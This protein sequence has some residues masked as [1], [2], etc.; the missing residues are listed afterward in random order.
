[1][2]SLGDYLIRIPTMIPCLLA[3]CLTVL[4]LQKFFEF[5]H[6]CL[7]FSYHHLC[8]SEFILVS[9]YKWK[10]N[11]IKIQVQKAYIPCIWWIYFLCTET[12]HDA[13]RNMKGPWKL[14]VSQ[15][16]C[17]KSSFR[18]GKPCYITHGTAPLD[19]MVAF[20]NGPDAFGRVVEPWHDNLFE[21][22]CDYGVKNN[23]CI[24]HKACFQE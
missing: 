2:L 9:P 10:K 16:P 4:A 15:C 18:A 19:P 13:W 11:R 23:R 8:G 12:K 6:Y 3:Y 20:V 5:S 17:W 24:D 1:M 22:C 21:A 7:P 14:I